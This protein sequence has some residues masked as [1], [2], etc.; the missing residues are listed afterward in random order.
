MSKRVKSTEDISRALVENQIFMNDIRQLNDQEGRKKKFYITTFGCQ[1]NEHDSEK[2]E[3]MLLQMGYVAT[4]EKAQADLVIINT[5]CVRENAELK[6]FGNLGHLKPLKTKN[7]HMKIAVCGCMMQQPHIVEAIQTKYKHVDLVFGTHNLHHFPR[8]LAAA[9]GS[10]SPMIEIWQEES[11]V[12]EGMPSTR[13]Y[14]MKAY[15]NIMYGCDNFCT[16][17]IV[18]YTRGR[19][20]SR[21]PEDII[22]EIKTLIAEGTL[23][24]CLLGQNV[25]SYGK[26][27]EQ[28]LAF[29]ELLK[30]VDALPGIQR[31]R[32]MTPHPKDFTEDLIQTIKHGKHLCEQIHLPIQAG[33]NALL[34]AM[35][36]YY[37]KESYLTLTKRI[38]AE[39]PDVAITTDIIIGF[40]GETEEDVAELI[41]VIGA[42]EYDTA[43][44]FIYSKRT[45][46]PAA[47]MPDQIEESV[48]HARFERVLATLNSIVIRK[49][50]EMKDLDVEVL[51]EGEARDGKGMLTG[52]T[53][54]N[55]V[56]NF[57]GDASLIGTLQIVKVTEPKN[58][59]L[60]GELK[61]L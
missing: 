18:P 15:V 20:R 54:N 48:K 49:N 4:T 59:S 53:R 50:Q 28:P 17:C 27:L 42:V 14:G 41:E 58:F 52:R 9:L 44:T 21:L 13:K 11:G 10:T 37:T 25:N 2:L 12:I 51:V 23:E 33:S 32:F 55:R 5:C 34:K 57:K 31:V 40:P 1:M 6:V 38:R 8:L 47:E 19:E 43:Y 39:I 29:H 22:N 3:G 61:K 26:D 45:G 46:T 35:N 24:V 16:Y 60:S 30:Q 36:R 7:P 56:V